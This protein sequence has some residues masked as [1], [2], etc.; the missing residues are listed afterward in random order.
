MRVRENKVNFK[1]KSTSAGGKRKAHPYL[2]K[3][4]LKSAARA[5]VRQAASETMD[6]LGYN[7]IVVGGWVVKKYRSGQIERI[8]PV[9]TAINPGGLL[10]D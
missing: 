5:S 6:L 3:R 9:Q 10:L 4:I 1:R 8:E 7:V 2:T